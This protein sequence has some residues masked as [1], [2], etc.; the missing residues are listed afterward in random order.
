MTL[1]M[2]RA[3][4]VLNYLISN[5]ID[6]ER[7]AYNAMGQSQPVAPNSTEQGRAKNRRTEIV[8]K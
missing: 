1:S 8:I 6:S 4:S 7:L 2:H 5:G 3:K